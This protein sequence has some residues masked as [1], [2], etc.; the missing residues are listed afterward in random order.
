MRANERSGAGLGLP[1]MVALVGSAVSARELPSASRGTSLSGSHRTPAATRPAA[2]A[3]VEPMA[4]AGH[5]WRPAHR[6]RDSID[7][8]PD[9]PVCESA[10]AGDWAGQLLHFGTGLVFQQTPRQQRPWRGLLNSH[11]IVIDFF[12]QGLVERILLG[13][14]NL[15][16]FIVE[17]RLCSKNNARKNEEDA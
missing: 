14:K 7:Q 5:L 15:G 10:A 9:P 17:D 4:M 3:R 11:A 2:A 6:R 1:V 8:G 16:A 12:L 13:L